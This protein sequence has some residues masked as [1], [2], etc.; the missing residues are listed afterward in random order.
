MGDFT[1]PKLPLTGDEKTLDELS[2]PDERAICDVEYLQAPFLHLEKTLP[3]AVPDRLQERMAVARQLAV[4]GF[5][6]HEFNAVS[7]FWSTS[8][9][10]MALKLKFREVNPGQVQLERK[11]NDGAAAETVEVPVASLQQRLTEGWRISSMAEFDGSFRAHLRWAFQAK[12]LPQ[13][14]SIPI[15]EIV[16]SF[17]NRF[18]FEIFPDRA[19]KDGLIGSNPT[20]GDIQGC[21]FRLSEEEQR[22]YQSCPAEVLVEELPK[23]SDELA[24]PEINLIVAPR[25]ALGAYQLAVDILG[26]LWG[27]ATDPMQIVD[28]PQ[29][30][31]RDKMEGPKVDARPITIYDSV[32]IPTGVRIPGRISFTFGA[33]SDGM[34]EERLFDLAETEI[35]EEIIT[36]PLLC[37]RLLECLDIQY[38]NYWIVTEMLTKEAAGS[39]PHSKPGDLDMVCGRMR[40]GKPDLD[41]ITCVQVKIRKVK[42]F[43][44]TGDFA[45]GSGTTQAHWTAK[46]GFDRTLLLHCI[47]RIPQPLPDGYAPSWNSIVNA[48]FERAA[49][50][51]FGVIREKFERDRELYGYGWIGWGQAC[52][53]SWKTCG[54]LAVDLVYPPP[55]RPAFDSEEA[56][57]T[58]TE[59]AQ[60][61]RT[62]LSQQDIRKLPVIVRCKHE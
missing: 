18:A 38:P 32:R 61:I 29:E 20:V 15:Q 1:F 44:E 16:N 35:I 45:S 13:D 4:Y 43:V 54:G 8:S 9:I 14:I 23:F 52:G 2:Q 25:S 37:T 41:F 28:Q 57:Q 48:D 50:S 60:S 7:M 33:G 51:C 58:R 56:R 27:R 17:N 26:R 5:F 19:A 6:C 47:V 46:M 39:W 36:S 62:L 21:W 3:G 11:A 34:P 31:D 59:V 40:H 42:S 30:W 22:R 24:H 53:N 49:K 55:H 12:L 10:E